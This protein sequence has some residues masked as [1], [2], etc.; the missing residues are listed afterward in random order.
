MRHSLGKLFVKR[1]ILAVIVSL[2]SATAH[3]GIIV[4]VLDTSLVA[5]GVGTVDVM[6]KYD[7]VSSNILSS[8]GLVLQITQVAGT[9]GQLQFTD[10]QT[11]SYA[12]TSSY[13]LFGDSFGVSSSISTVNWVNDNYFS[14]DATMSSGVIVPVTEVL[15]ARLDL[16]TSNTIGGDSYLI[17]LVPADSSYTE[18]DLG[19]PFSFRDSSHAGTI[20]ISS[21][22][23]PS[24]LTLL[25]L[26][27]TVVG[28]A[29]F[30]RMM[31]R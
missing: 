10:P 21:V 13:V 15:L 31:Q 16:S 7:S 6:I 12:S 24:S 4:D 28:W 25:G 9:T 27:L 30:R 3:A 19:G 2:V 23:E 20:F 14:T 22:P 26:G 29:R 11:N 18:A 17:S 5:G 1:S 8:Y